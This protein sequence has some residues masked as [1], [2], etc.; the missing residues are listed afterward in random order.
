MIIQRTYQRIKRKSKHF[1]VYTE[2]RPYIQCRLGHKLIAVFINKQTNR[3]KI[4]HLY[5]IDKTKYSRVLAFLYLDWHIRK[6]KYLFIR[7]PTN[8]PHIQANMIHID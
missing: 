8:N 7:F 5:L 1:L 6:H 4:I 3:I 2:I